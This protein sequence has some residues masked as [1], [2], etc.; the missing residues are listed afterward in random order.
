MIKGVKG[1]DLTIFVRFGGLNLKKQKGYKTEWNKNDD[2]AYHQPP[3]SRGFYAFPKVAQEF[4]LISSI[5]KFQPGILPKEPIIDWT[6]L[7]ENSS[8]EAKVIY[9][10]YE[11]SRKNALSLCRKEFKKTTGYI[12]HHLEEYTPHNEIIETHGYW[13]KTSLKNWQKAFNRMSI[14]LRT[15]DGEKDQYIKNK[16]INET[17]GILGG[18]CADHCEVFINEKV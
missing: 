5:D 16:N 4:F 17:R 9:N 6:I 13:V 10:N 12:W 14:K 15:R 2:M 7:D 18:F 11:K 8:E 1:K 3:A